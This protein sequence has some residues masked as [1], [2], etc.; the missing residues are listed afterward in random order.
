MNLNTPAKFFVTK[1]EYRY[2]IKYLCSSFM[3]ILQNLCQP[4][5]LH[6]RTVQFEAE[7]FKFIAFEAIEIPAVLRG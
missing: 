6:E 1:V 3:D 7:N 5:L 4:C 2:F